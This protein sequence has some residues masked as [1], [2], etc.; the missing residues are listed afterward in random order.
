MEKT[1]YIKNYECIHCKTRN[2]IGVKNCTYCGRELQNLHS[3]LECGNCSTINEGNAK[4]CKSCGYKLILESSE[5]LDLEFLKKHL[6]GK[7]NIL[8]MIGEGGFSKIYLAEH[9]SLHRKEVIKLLKAGMSESNDIRNRFL[10]ESRILA[11]LNHPNIIR[12]TD[13]YE[14]EGRSFYI[15][16][17][18]EGKTLQKKLDENIKFTQE[19]A[20]KI[21][22]DVSRILAEV[23]KRGIIHRD[24]KPDNLLIDD[25]FYPTIIDFGI[26]KS[27]DSNL[28]KTLKTEVGFMMGTAIYMSP[29]QIEG[30][31]IDFRTDIY[32]LGIILYQ[33]L[34]NKIPFDGQPHEILHKKLTQDLPLLDKEIDK[35]KQLQNIL[36]K[37]T[38]RNKENRYPSIQDF[39]LD[40]ENLINK[41]IGLKNKVLKTNKV[42]NPK[43]Y[44]YNFFNNQ[45]ILL[46]SILLTIILF[47]LYKIYPISE[48]II[49]PG[50]I[51]SIGME[52]ILIPKGE[53][54]MG[55]V[56]LDPNCNEDEMP[57]HKVEITKSFS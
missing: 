32:S 44:S 20:I 27:D 57:S 30:I 16:E 18:K 54:V 53:F 47:I 22:L 17:F 42:S 13:V 56:D 5:D 40:L 48:N 9:I 41:K 14:L 31:D 52:F 21:I 39:Q 49:K 28:D 24:L 12:I 33:L 45:N 50:H 11:K 23:H 2:S 4:Y 35:F 37:A 7:Y 46:A 43:I 8:E 36:I 3:E 10:R 25:D 19:Q 51:N 26:S 55:C 6:F 29:E 15:M 34:S 1:E 38:E